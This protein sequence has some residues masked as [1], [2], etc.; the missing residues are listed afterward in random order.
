[1]IELKMLFTGSTFIEIENRI[2]NFKSSDLNIDEMKPVYQN[3]LKK[4]L[5]KN[6]KIKIEIN[7]KSF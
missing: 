5:N 4:Y 6:L 3:I 1:M 7:F 2:V